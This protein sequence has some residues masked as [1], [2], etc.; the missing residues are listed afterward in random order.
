MVLNQQWIIITH[1][2][3]EVVGMA[4]LLTE[5][6]HLIFMHYGSTLEVRKLL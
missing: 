2:S 1:Q 6:F 4:Y 3:L 5:Y